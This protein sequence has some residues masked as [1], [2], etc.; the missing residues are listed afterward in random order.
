M[1]DLNCIAEIINRENFTCDYTSNCP[2][3]YDDRCTQVESIKNL[4]NHGTIEENLP[5][6]GLTLAGVRASRV[7]NECPILKCSEVTE[8]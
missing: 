7:P 1:A 2:L 6:A 8:P 5:L 4:S 3:G